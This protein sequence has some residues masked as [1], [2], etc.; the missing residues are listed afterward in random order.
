MTTKEFNEKYKNYLEDGFYG[1]DI[2]DE[3]VIS[4]L[5]KEFEK[6]IKIKGFQYSQIKLKFGLARVYAKG[7][8]FDQCLKLE[9]Q[10]NKIIQLKDAE[11]KI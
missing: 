4:M 7:I 9:K 3:D 11:S 6:L 10:I 8:D 1:L 5:D 2:H